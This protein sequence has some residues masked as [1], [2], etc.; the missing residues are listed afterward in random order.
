MTKPNH[1]WPWLMDDVIP[2]DPDFEL[3][4]VEV[5]PCGRWRR[6]A[7]PYDGLYIVLRDR[8]GT[9]GYK[10]SIEEY[11]TDQ[12]PQLLGEELW[13][14]PHPSFPGQGE[15]EAIGAG[16][17]IAW[18]APTSDLNL[19]YTWCRSRRNPGS[20]AVV[21]VVNQGRVAY[22]LSKDQVDTMLALSRLH[23]EDREN[24]ERYDEY[25]REDYEGLLDVVHWY[26][27]PDDIQML[28]TLKLIP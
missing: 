2:D 18:R 26:E 19:W 15:A 14:R 12:V 1:V 8:P 4:C 5:S 23:P 20:M 13:W 21:P 9:T 27:D 16:P 25:H 6:G 17:Q 10:S 7:V 22:V 11:M 24:L 28:R 3:P